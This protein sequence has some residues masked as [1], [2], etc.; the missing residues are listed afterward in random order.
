MAVPFRKSATQVAGHSVFTPR[1]VARV[2]AG[3]GCTEAGLAL[4]WTPPAKSLTGDMQPS[5]DVAKFGQPEGG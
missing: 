4:L 5:G 3:P 1:E 2:G